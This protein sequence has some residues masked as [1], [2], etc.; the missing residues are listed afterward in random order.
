MDMATFIQ[1]FAQAAP[2]LKWR[3]DGKRLRG[4]TPEGQA[5]CPMVAVHLAMGKV[6]RVGAGWH[7]L[8]AGMDLELSI[9]DMQLIL[10]A[11]DGNCSDNYPAFDLRQ[12]FLTS[13]G[14]RDEASTPS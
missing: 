9:P 3:L 1:K 5:C 7:W 6:S 11:A 14:V 2:Q 10:K 13:A 12:S 8:N 4:Y